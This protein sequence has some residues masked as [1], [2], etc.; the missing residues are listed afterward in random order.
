MVMSSLTWSGDAG[1]ESEIEKA[2]IDALQMHFLS[3][4]LQD[5]IGRRSTA[6]V[7]HFKTFRKQDSELTFSAPIKP[8]LSDS[9]LTANYKVDLIA[10]LGSQ[11]S[12]V[13]LELCLNNR[14]AIGT[15]LLKLDLAL[16]SRLTPP[17]S[18]LMIVVAATR[19]LLD[20][21]GWDKAYGDS[22]EYWHLLET[23]ICNYL[24][25]RVLIIELHAIG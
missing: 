11:E 8:L 3:L 2:F 4:P 15:N 6:L 12:L 21:G 7:Q 13:S 20:Q 10:S 19:Q 17:K 23:G 22:S 18:G 24:N 5:I 1:P 16:S 14:E 9:K 25:A